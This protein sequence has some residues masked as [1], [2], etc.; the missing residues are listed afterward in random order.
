MKL[1]TKDAPTTPLNADPGTWAAHREYGDEPT[2]ALTL[3]KADGKATDTDYGSF[4]RNPSMDADESVE[5]RDCPA[6]TAPSQNTSY[7]IVYQSQQPILYRVVVAAT[8]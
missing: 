8:R 4:V 7:Q 2:D 3:P 5:P 6:Q 1:K